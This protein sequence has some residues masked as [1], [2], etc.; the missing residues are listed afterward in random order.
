MAKKQTRLLL[1]VAALGAL[2]MVAGVVAVVL[3][4]QTDMPTFTQE[5]KWL[6]A[7]IA[8]QLREAPGSEALLVDPL[9][10]PPLSTELVASLQHAA[11]DDAVHGVY[12]ELGPVGAGWAT[13]QEVRGALKTVVDAGKPCVVSADVLTT[14]EYVLASPCELHL[15]PAG[16]I[17]VEG[18]STT[19][20]YYAE[21][22]E[23]YGV[24][25]NFEHVGDFKSAVEPYERTG[26]SEAAQAA[27][28]ALLDSIFEQMLADMA[29]GRGVE[30]EV[31]RGWLSDP[32][33]TPSLALER[34]MIDA[35]SYPDE[36]RAGL[37]RPMAEDEDATDAEAGTTGTTDDDTTGTTE[38][39]TD[40]GDDADDAPDFLKLSE[41]LRDRRQDWKKGGEKVA[42]IYA[43]G[44]IVSGTSNQDM[45]GS[46]YIGDRTVI[47]QLRKAREDDAVKAV[48]LRVSSPGGSGTASDAMWRE[49]VRTRDE[50]PLIVSMGDYAASG[51]YYMA[52]AGDRIFASPG[53]ITGSIGVFGGKLNL[54]GVYESFGVHLHTDKRG[55]YATLLSST[56]DFDEAERAKFKSFLSGFYTVFTTKAAEG[57]G[58]ALADLE[59]VAQ[60]RVWTGEQALAHGL[61]DELGGL[62]AAIAYA[63]EAAELDGYAIQRIPERRSF[64]DQLVEEL[65]NPSPD[66]GAALS[67]LPLQGAAL[68]TAASLARLERVLADGSPAALLP[69]DLTL[70]DPHALAPAPVSH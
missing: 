67:Q 15:A 37:S 12:I 35:M 27:N 29:D 5:P 64:I 38:G 16:L 40:E 2:I 48:V 31:A 6:K 47:K 53:T 63:A 23:R 62:D 52:M 59:A 61:V 33:M 58:M 70:E 24:S 56:K 28:D 41:Y 50:K 44:A 8:G 10:L 11:T 49:I 39:E 14:K 51:G 9:D 22:F 17:F 65:S 43:E 18:M 19:R 55:E 20:M 54:A 34:G 57:R 25:A 13:V 30:L 69:G 7:R 45:F 36:V 32:P 42:V 4:V 60:G 66:A 21:T 68:R 1:I 3:L 46:R 26:P